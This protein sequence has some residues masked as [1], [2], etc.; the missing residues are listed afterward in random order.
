MLFTPLTSAHEVVFTLAEELLAAVAAATGE[1]VWVPAER[2][3][4]LGMLGLPT[5]RL[6]TTDTTAARI[7]AVLRHSVCI[8]HD[9]T[10]SVEQTVRASIAYAREASLLPA[11]RK[12]HPASTRAR[13]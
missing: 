3:A 8:F 9:Y 11:C 10:S 4:L 1:R 13:K 6:F 2:W 12:W 7:H 5:A